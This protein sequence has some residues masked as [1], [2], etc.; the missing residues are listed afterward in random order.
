MVMLSGVAM[1]EPIDP[2]TVPFG[3]EDCDHGDGTPELI[4]E[5]RLNLS[6]VYGHTDLEDAGL[7]LGG[8]DPSVNGFSVPGL[9]FGMDVIYGEHLAGFTESIFSWTNDDGWE[10]EL[11]E[12]YINFLNLPGG[13]EIHAGRYFASIGTQNDIHNHGWKFADA[14]LGN[15]RFLG[16]DGVILNGVEITWSPPTRWDDRLIIGFGDTIRHE[17]DHGHEEEHDEHGDDDHD[18][19]DHD[20]HDEHGHSEEAEEAL[21]DRDVLAVRYQVTKWPGDDCKF[22]Y[23]A[24]YLQ[25]KNFMGHSARLYGLDLTYTWLEDEDHS[26][27]LTW[28][29]EVMMRDIDT[30]EGNFEE[31]S[32]SSTAL[33]KLNP[34]WE[35]G[36]RYGYLEGVEDPEL[37]ERHRISPVLTRFFQL[38]GT[39]AMTRLQYNYDHSEERGDD[40]SIWLQF[41]FEW[42]GGDAHV[43]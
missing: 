30:D 40:H 2:S 32:F 15:V 3:G 4:V 34:E 19:D 25:G 36:L 18:D 35:I 26:R 14:Y 11:E 12:L 20:E 9:S 7:A 42:G 39:E 37:P 8:H 41:R 23:G 31:F 21:W 6:A 22:V 1:S 33:Y 16:D 29:N 17:H 24:S 43:H 5:P 13:F 27:Q 28:R 38:G 10:A